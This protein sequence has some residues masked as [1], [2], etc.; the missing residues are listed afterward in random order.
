MHRLSHIIYTK[1][2]Q[3][4]NTR[5]DI[6]HPELLAQLVYCIAVTVAADMKVS[7][8]SVGPSANLRMGALLCEGRVIEWPERD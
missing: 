6:R 3:V 1:Y 2:E 4:L 7:I 8:P 5:D